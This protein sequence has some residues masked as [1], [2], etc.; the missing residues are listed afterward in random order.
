MLGKIRYKKPYIINTFLPFFK[1]L[2][3]RIQCLC[4]FERG[5]YR[6]YRMLKLQKAKVYTSK[7]LVFTGFITIFYINV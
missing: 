1:S 6:M 4:G 3:I 5:M 2:Y 7:T